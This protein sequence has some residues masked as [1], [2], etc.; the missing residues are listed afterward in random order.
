MLK[1][2]A[3]KDNVLGKMIGG[4]TVA[5]HAAVAARGFKDAA[6]DP[7]TVINKHLEDF[8]LYEIGTIDEDTLMV[9]PLL[10]DNQPVTPEL[11]VKGRAL[12][13]KE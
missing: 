2:Y 12:I 1:L 13:N 10:I 9:M 11:V 4:V 7:Q 3:V 5:A 6:D 8:D